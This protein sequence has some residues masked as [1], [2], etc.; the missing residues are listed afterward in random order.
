MSLFHLL[1]SLDHFP[2]IDIQVLGALFILPWEYSSSAVLK[3]SLVVEGLVWDYFYRIPHRRSQ[4]ITEIALLHNCPVF[5]SNSWVASA[6][7]EGCTLLVVCTN[8]DHR[9]ASS[10]SRQVILCR[11]HHACCHAIWCCCSYWQHSRQAAFGV[12]TGLTC[13]HW[14]IFIVAFTLLWGLI[15]WRWRLS[16]T[17]LNLYTKSVVRLKKVSFKVTD[18][19]L[20]SGCVF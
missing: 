7:A 4:S 17:T 13:Q 12:C 5:K 16:V 11:K 2:V 18:S 20:G 15:S 8:S 19:V 9:L 3:I 6:L 10:V 14:R 1:Y